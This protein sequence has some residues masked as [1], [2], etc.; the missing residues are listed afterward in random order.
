M[1]VFLANRWLQYLACGFSFNTPAQ[2]NVRKSRTTLSSHVL[3]DHNVTT[4][5]QQ[6]F[7]SQ[8]ADLF[9]AKSNVWQLQCSISA[10]H[11]QQTTVAFCQR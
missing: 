8:S 2:H 11:L 7:L 4:F 5:M 1:P 10:T 6:P 3:S 9:L